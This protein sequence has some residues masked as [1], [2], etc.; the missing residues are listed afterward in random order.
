VHPVV[1]EL[2]D[3]IRA[4]MMS[5]KKVLKAI[6]ADRDDVRLPVMGARRM[7]GLWPLLEQDVAAEVVRLVRGE[8]APVARVVV[9]RLSGQHVRAHEQE[10]VGQWG[11]FLADPLAG[12]G[13]RMSLTN[14]RILGLYLGAVLKAGPQMQ[15]WEERYQRYPSYAVEARG[16]DGSDS[17]MSAEG[18][19]NSIA[20]VNTA[21]EPGIPKF[22]TT[23]QVFAPP[24]L[25]YSVIN[26][27]FQPFAVYLPDKHGGFRW[28][29]IVA[30][31]A[32][33]NAFD[34]VTN[35]H[36]MI[37]AD[38]GDAYLPNFEPQIKPDPDEPTEPTEVS[39]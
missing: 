27:V 7:E 18:A 9:G 6:A 37:V 8:K 20:F 28:E 21:L 32:L 12:A 14:G 15:A 16:R 34:P 2:A 36:R 30:L 39:Q 13:Q 29:A 19:A 33:D 38:Y 17:T 11:V 4:Q 25:D 35:P 22:I 1:R 3:R 31:I 23:G 24:A 5:G 26:A 10:M